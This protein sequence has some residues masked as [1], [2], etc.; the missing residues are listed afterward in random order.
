[1]CFE[2]ARTGVHK[3]C[4]AS[5]SWEAPLGALDRYLGSLTAPRGPESLPRLSFAGGRIADP[6]QNNP[7][8]M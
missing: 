5:R 6:L 3:A 4:A 7:K 1:M 8:V 2:E